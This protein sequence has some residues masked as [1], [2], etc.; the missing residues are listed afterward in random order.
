MPF[1]LFQILL[2]KGWK[3]KYGRDKEKTEK[4]TKIV[5]FTIFG[6][7]FGAQNEASPNDPRA[8]VLAEVGA[9]IRKREGESK[10]KRDR[11]T[12]RACGGPKRGANYGPSSPVSIPT[13]DESLAQVWLAQWR[14]TRRSSGAGSGADWRK[15]RRRRVATLSCKVVP[16]LAHIFNLLG[17]FLNGVILA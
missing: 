15:W 9:V 17:A 11:Y 8:Y 7:F 12:E 16:C 3:R 6:Y 4:K 1:L 5:F 13:L 2:K 14:R 10:K